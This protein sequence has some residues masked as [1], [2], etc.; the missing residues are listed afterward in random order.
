MYRNRIKNKNLSSSKITYGGHGSVFL[1]SHSTQRIHLR[2]PLSHHVRALTFTTTYI[3]L[4]FYC[5]PNTPW[6]AL[7]SCLVVGERTRK[8]RRKSQEPWQ[9]WQK[10]ACLPD[11]CRDLPWRFWSRKLK[12]IHVHASWTFP[13]ECQSRINLTMTTDIGCK[14]NMNYNLQVTCIKVIL[15]S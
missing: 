5:I 3:S 7:A 4:L 1:F 10:L 11:Q 13:T 14:K 8:F 15:T 12:K 6:F 9:R 2:Q